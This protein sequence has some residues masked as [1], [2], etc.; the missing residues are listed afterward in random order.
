MK[1]FTWTDA[2]LIV[3]LLAGAVF[4]FPLLRSMAPGSVTIQ[5][6]NRVIAE[7]PLDENRSLEV[8]GIYGPMIIEIKDGAVSVQRSSC[9][10]QLCRFSGSVNHTGSQIVCVPNHVLISIKASEKKVYD[11]IAQ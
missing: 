1:R 11:A 8:Q 7:Y 6:G 4:T 5:K 2:L 9:P 3:I 10:H